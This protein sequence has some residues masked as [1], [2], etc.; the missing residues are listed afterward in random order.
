MFKQLTAA[1]I[2][3]G[4]CL[5]AANE[6]RRDLSAQPRLLFHKLLNNNNNNQN[7]NNNNYR[8]QPA[9]IFLGGNQDS[10]SHRYQR[11]P[12]ED[13]YYPHYP[14]PHPPPRPRYPG[15]ND[16]EYSGNPHVIVINP[17]NAQNISHVSQPAPAATVDDG[18]RSA[19]PIIDIL[20]AAEEPEPIN[21]AESPES[22]PTVAVLPLY[23][24]DDEYDDTSS[25]VLERQTVRG[26]NPKLLLNLLSQQ[27]KRRRRFQEA[28]A[29]IYL[30][31]YNA[32]RK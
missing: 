4:V 26:L 25:A 9:I 21:V 22:E 15:Y 11:P 3:F 30:R 29:S 18:G 12:W 13:Y 10:N 17:I 31:N 23:N 27:D 28:V 6:G 8:Q 32:N 24:N 5:A 1:L 19:F 2:C 14:H 7:N 20:Q 16:S